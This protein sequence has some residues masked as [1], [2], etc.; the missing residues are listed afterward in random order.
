LFL[1]HIDGIV[2][3]LG[4]RIGGEVPGVAVVVDVFRVSANG[5]GFALGDAAVDCVDGAERV[6][7]SLVVEEGPLAA[8]LEG[9]GIATSGGIEVVYR[10]K[11]RVGVLATPRL[12]VIDCSIVS[13][14]LPS[15]AKRGRGLTVGV[16][17]AAAVPEALLEAQDIRGD[18]VARRAINAE[19]SGEKSALNQS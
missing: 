19:L 16:D 18:S 13:W 8:G 10:G 4:G 5:N 7:I 11:N 6:Y 3:L 1:P 14:E 12:A 2:K 17:V 15:S 9:V